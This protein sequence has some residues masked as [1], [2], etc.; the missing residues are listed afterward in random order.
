[1]T[2][3]K[4]L[5]AVLAA[6]VLLTGCG[7]SG[8]PA[9]AGPP[10]VTGYGHNAATV[11][12]SLGA[13]CARTRSFGADTAR[14]EHAADAATPALI[15]QTFPSADEQTL[16]LAAIV[17]GRS[18]SVPTLCRVVMLGVVVQGDPA[19]AVRLALGNVA[20]FAASHHG[21]VEGTGC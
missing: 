13:F 18:T 15:V 16:G 19:S 5:C 14:C 2:G 17:N 10:I 9:S 1:M 11:A 21:R 8:H 6:A 3:V 4:R 12:G 7:S 20:R